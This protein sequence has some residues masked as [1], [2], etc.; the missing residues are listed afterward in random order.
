MS[1]QGSPKASA[2]KAKSAQVR[3]YSS[4]AHQY[5]RDVVSGKV[6][7]C[8]WIRLAGKRSLDDLAQERDVKFPYRFDSKKAADAC[9][10]IELLPH[11]KGKWM[12][13]TN[14]RPQRMVLEPSQVWEVASIFGWVEKA[15]GLRR[16][17]RAYIKKPRK[18]GKSPEAA[19]IGLKMFAAD[20]E[21]GAEVYCG[22]TTEKQAWE[23]FRP[24][25]LMAMKTPELQQ[26]F[27]VVVNAK[28]L[29]IEEDY[30]RFEPI[31]GKP[32]DGAGPSCSITDEFHE[33]L[34][35]DLLDTMETGMAAREQPLSLIITTAG[36]FIEGPC[37][38]V[39]KEAKQVLEK[40]IENDQ[41]FIA[42]YG[43]DEE[44]YEW[45]GEKIPADDWTSDL[46]LRKANPLFDVSVSAQFLRA[47]Q[48]QAIQHAYQQNTFKTKHL[49]IWVGAR[50]AWMN[51][52]A[53]RKCEDRTLRL[54]DFL[55]RDC[56]EGEDLATRIDLASRCKVFVREENG[57]RHYYAFSRNYVPL[58][59]A[60]DGYHQ[61]YQKWLY[62]SEQMPDL[63]KYFI[64]H[65]G[66][67]I[68][69]SLIQRE[70]EEDLRRFN[71]VCIAFDP[72]SAQQMQQVLA[73]HVAEDA[74]ITVPQTTQYLSAAMKEV[75]AAVF[76]GRFHHD[77]N[78][79][80]TWAISNVIV[81]PDG[82][83]EI[84]PRKEQNGISKIDP[85]SALF[86]AMNRAMV[87]EV[88]RPFTRPMIGLL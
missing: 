18:N 19:G 70:I 87:G 25:K 88:R 11:V 23:V 49:N 52:V 56:I 79:V 58:D 8:K 20:N 31:I 4:I 10:F 36:S 64:G 14:G 74:V 35:P 46:A 84:F 77:G 51:M 66:P 3:R 57:L 33:H 67:E 73:G 72:W 45:N 29:V 63:A 82:N 83:D 44:P 61:H 62:E 26:Y 16:F 54:E 7:A 81:K 40:L 59:R 21:P 75:E 48:K 2:A 42:I 76:A 38:Q 69:L 65:P 28:S 30:S 27:G 39:E 60:M 9:R 34:T 85:A 53:W 22:A 71:Y 32:G 41:F 80:F 24:A 15:T 1:G 17:R 50:A 13:G 78:P 55:G 6:L 5:A 68:Q 12:R 37:H 47:A 86:N 43:I